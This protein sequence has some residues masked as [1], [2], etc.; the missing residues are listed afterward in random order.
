VGHCGPCTYEV[1]KGK[2][3]AEMWEKTKV[4]DNWH[5]EKERKQTVWQ[6]SLKV[7][8]T[9]LKRKTNGAKA[10]AAHREKS[11]CGYGKGNAE[12]KKMETGK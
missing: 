3:T 5:T 11:K 1:T 12:K 2:G 6:A 4:W 8:S 9:C 7:G 10:A